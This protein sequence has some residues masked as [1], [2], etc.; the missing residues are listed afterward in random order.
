MLGALD[1]I[2]LQ[3]L[4]SIECPQEL[5]TTILTDKVRVLGV[6]K[7]RNLHQMMQLPLQLILEE[8][9]YLTLLQE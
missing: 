7:T 5:D 6:S 2:S 8:S 3:E 9:Y 1:K 4:C